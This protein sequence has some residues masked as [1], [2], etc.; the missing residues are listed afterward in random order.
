MKQTKQLFK[1]KIT[2]LLNE[3]GSDEVLA[4]AALPAYA[5]KNP[6]IDYIFW[7]RLKAAAGFISKRGAG[8]KATV[9]DFGCGTGLF[10]YELATQGHQVF[11]LDLDL[12]PVNLL[13]S[14]INYPD[15][16]HFEQGDFFKIDFKGKQFD[17]IVALDVLEHI[18][19]D[20]LPDFLEKFNTLLSPGGCLVI[21][22]PSE[23]WLYKIGRKL[24][25]S[26]FTGEYHETTIAK[27]KTRCEVLFNV[28][29]I[30][31]LVWPMVLF[32]IFSAE[33]R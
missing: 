30:T 1:T 19:L 3:K 12:T 18:P 29:T 25:G 2:E 21:S 15:S 11:A 23:N 27:I 33:K 17:F 5:H 31:K 4:E 10:S 7:Q 28:K 6:L 32:E 26:D 8:K 24:A 9:L 16:I 20:K 13:K 14:R 22:G